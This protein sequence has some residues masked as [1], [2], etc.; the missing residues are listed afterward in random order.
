VYNEYHQLDHRPENLALPGVLHGDR[1]VCTPEC[2]RVAF[3]ADPVFADVHYL[4]NYLLLDP[5]QRAT[6]EWLELSWSA[7][8]QGRR[9]EAGLAERPFLGWFTPFQTYV[10]PRVRVSADALPFRPVRGVYVTISAIENGDPI[11]IQRA[12]AWDDQVRVPT[13][14]ERT[15]A[16]GAMAH[17]SDPTAAR[18]FSTSA[19]S[20]VFN[21]RPNLRLHIFYLDED[22]LTFAAEVH[23]RTTA[24]RADGETP[25]T[26][27]LTPLFSSP[28][29]TIAPWEWT[30]FDD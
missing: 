10:S 12:L 21:D 2:A 17:L 25:D 18:P 30:W 7:F 28:F 26:G 16:A 14:L 11:E 24:W 27:V 1:W 15:G 23:A 6:D 5:V 29:Y 20:E 8:Q 22:P 3:H 4:V 19:G 13:L 9:P